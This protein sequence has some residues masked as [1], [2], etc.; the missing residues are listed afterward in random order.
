MEDNSGLPDGLGLNE[1]NQIKKLLQKGAKLA[2]NRTKLGKL[3]KFGT[4]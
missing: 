3:A 2:K 1:P 4:I